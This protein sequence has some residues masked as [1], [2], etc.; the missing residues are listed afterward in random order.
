MLLA[1]GICRIVYRFDFSG[2]MSSL[3]QSGDQEW[4]TCGNTLTNR[5]LA[6]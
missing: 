6:L 4:M 2:N 5:H 3:Y 1:Y